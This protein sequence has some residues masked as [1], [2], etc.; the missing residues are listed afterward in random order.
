[1][2]AFEKGEHDVLQF[3][4]I[5]H[6]PRK[7]LPHI[8]AFDAD[9]LDKAIAHALIDFYSNTDLII[10]AVAGEHAMRAEGTTQHQAELA[11]IAQEIQHRR[12]GS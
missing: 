10:A 12:R 5:T 11:S 4:Q 2:F 8:G 6:D 9:L 1:M 3:D 7:W